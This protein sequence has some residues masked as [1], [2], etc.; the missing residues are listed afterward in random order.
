MTKVQKVILEIF[1]KCN[2]QYTNQYNK[3]SFLT[4]LDG[5]TNFNKI[6]MSAKNVVISM[7]MK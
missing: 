6:R 3:T 5:V 1:R 4:K 7:P 2:E